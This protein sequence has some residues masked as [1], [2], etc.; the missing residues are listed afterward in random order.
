MFSLKLGVKDIPMVFYENNSIWIH[1][2]IVLGLFVNQGYGC[3]SILRLF[4][5]Y[6]GN[7]GMPCKGVKLCSPMHNANVYNMGD[8]WNELESNCLPPYK[9][10]RLK[11]FLTFKEEALIMSQSNCRHNMVGF[12]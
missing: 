10:C 8:E 4:L 9:G 11:M 1:G 6:F 2:P 5:G 7:H 3:R 12:L